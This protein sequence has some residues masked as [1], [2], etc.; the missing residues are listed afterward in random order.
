MVQDD[1]G[2]SWFVQPC[3]PGLHRQLTGDERG[4]T[5]HLVVRLQNGML[6]AIASDPQKVPNKSTLFPFFLCN[7]HN[8]SYSWSIKK[9]SDY[10]RGRTCKE[11]P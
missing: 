9:Q 11:N 2:Q 7:V 4:A 3:V 10:T 1:I 8:L 6:S 5:A